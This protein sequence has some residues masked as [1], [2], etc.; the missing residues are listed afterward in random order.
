MKLAG[1]TAEGRRAEGK[2]VRSEER[3]VADA[4]IAVSND[5]GGVRGVGVGG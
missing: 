4:G 2:K 1:N 5:G 3:R